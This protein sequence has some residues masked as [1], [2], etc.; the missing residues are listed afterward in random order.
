MDAKRFYIPLADA[1]SGRKVSLLLGG[2]IL[3]DV[4]LAARPKG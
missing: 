1:I 3:S 4:W 2:P